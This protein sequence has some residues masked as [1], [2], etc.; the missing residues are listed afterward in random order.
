MIAYLILPIIFQSGTGKGLHNNLPSCK[1]PAKSQD[2]VRWTGYLSVLEEYKIILINRCQDKNQ[3]TILGDFDNFFGGDPCSGV[4]KY[5]NVTYDCIA[6]KGEDVMSS[7]MWWHQWVAALDFLCDVLS[8]QP[9]EN[10]EK[11]VEMI[12]SIFLLNC[13]CPASLG[14]C[15]Q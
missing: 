4:H 10:W 12:F 14:C 3:C 6:A 13:F 2:W 7:V 5:L 1:F 8:N 15:L 11:V 9:V